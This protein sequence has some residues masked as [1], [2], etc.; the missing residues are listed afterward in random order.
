MPA[1]QA[2][3]TWQYPEACTRPGSGNLNDALLNIFLKFYWKLVQ[4]RN[5]RLR[6]KIVAYYHHGSR[7]PP[8]LIP[9]VGLIAGLLLRLYDEPTVL[10]P[11]AAK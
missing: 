11:T 4:H 9:E 1:S 5:E 10:I 6:P 7:K 8:L 2:E 3:A